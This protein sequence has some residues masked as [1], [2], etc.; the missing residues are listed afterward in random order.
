MLNLVEIIYSKTKI[1]NEAEITIC[2][3]N[4]KIYNRLIANFIKES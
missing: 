3:N 4:W 2:N 1:I